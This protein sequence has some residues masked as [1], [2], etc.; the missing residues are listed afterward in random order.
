MKTHWD[1]DDQKFIQVFESNQLTEELFNHEAHLRLAWIYIR[2]YGV[3][4]AIERTQSQLK[5]YV[6]FLGAEDIYNTTLTIAGVKVVNHFMLKAQS[7]N[8]S[9][10]LLEFPRLK[11]NFKE[12]IESHYSVDIFNSPNAKAEYLQPDMM[13]FD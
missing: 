11:S 10:F 2:S 3:N 1:L 12:L 6:K 8:F 13:P 9:D 5:S 4:L 7:N